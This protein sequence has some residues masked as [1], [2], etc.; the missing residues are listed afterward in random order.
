MPHAVSPLDL[1]CINRHRVKLWTFRL[2]V[3]NDDRNTVQG[4]LLYEVGFSFRF[5]L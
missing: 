1:K 5:A 2:C 4:L 3:M